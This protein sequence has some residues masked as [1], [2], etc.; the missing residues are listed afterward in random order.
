MKKYGLEENIASFKLPET[1][2]VYVKKIILPDPVT[3]FEA[4]R[5]TFEIE[6]PTVYVKESV[7]SAP[8]YGYVLRQL[9]IKYLSYTGEDGGYIACYSHNKEHGVYH[10]GGGIYLVGQIWLEGEYRVLRFEPTGYEGVYPGI[11][12]VSTIPELNQKC[13]QAFPHAKGDCW[14]GNETGGWYQGIINT[15]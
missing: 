15:K 10:V 12:D 14:A 3:G 11:E 13:N 4:F 5:S 7:V 6:D 9:P 2:A 1:F 8:R